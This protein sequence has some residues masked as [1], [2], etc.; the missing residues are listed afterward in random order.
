MRLVVWLH[1]KTNIPST[2]SQTDAQVRTVQTGAVSDA[3]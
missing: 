2:L 1:I 3:R